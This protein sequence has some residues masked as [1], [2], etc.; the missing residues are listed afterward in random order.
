VVSVLFDGGTVVSFQ[1]QLVAQDGHD[2]WT[3]VEVGFSVRFVPVDRRFSPL[4]VVA[5]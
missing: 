1:R 5:S 3:A 2:A 4:S